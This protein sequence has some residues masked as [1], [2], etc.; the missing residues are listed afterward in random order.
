MKNKAKIL[1]LDIETSPN[2]SMVWGHYE[3]NVLAVEKYWHILSWSAK[4]LGGKQTTKCLA[5]YKTYR[6]DKEN[7]Y[8][9]V[10]ELYELM[11]EADIV[12]AHNGIDFDFKKV[13]TRLILHGFNPLPPCKQVDTKRMAKR[14][15]AFDSNKLDDLGDFFKIGRKEQTGGFKLWQD[16][17]AGDLKA[18]NKMK[19]Y[20]A[21]DVRLLEKVYIKLR[22]W[23]K[24]HPNIGLYAEEAVCPK[25]GSSDIHFRGWAINSTTKYRRFQCNE[26]GGWGRITSRERQTTNL[27]NI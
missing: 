17:M 10:K 8:E 21:Q 16:C 15:F 22:P 18:W 2:L 4:W 14:S 26:C 1:L 11:S 27:T 19:T 12:I 20:N 25:C 13:N 5:D 9:L 3:Q 7:D 6:K 24:Q 23:D